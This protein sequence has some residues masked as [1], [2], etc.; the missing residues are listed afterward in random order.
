MLQLSPEKVAYPLRLIFQRSIDSGRFPD[1]WKK[2]NV[3]PIHKKNSRQFVSNYRPISLLPIFG[4]ILE[5]IV[6]DQLYLFL[7]DNELLSKSQSGF[8]PGDSCTY[9]LLSITSNIFDS[10]ENY[11]ETR[12]LFL[13]ISRAFDKVWHDGLI[14]KLKA[15]GIRGNLLNFL[16][17]YVS[18]R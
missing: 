7:N 16:Q 15:N 11:D 18:N 17:N 1:C 9:Q 5:K 3:Q 4:K 14:H 10:F 6:F 13:D 2:A 8:W 12:A